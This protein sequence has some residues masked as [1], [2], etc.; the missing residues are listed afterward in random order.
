MKKFFSVSGVLVLL[1]S[2]IMIL[3]SYV[4]TG[5]HLLNNEFLANL[6]DYN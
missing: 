4:K 5:N 3:L 6:E 1:L 2:A